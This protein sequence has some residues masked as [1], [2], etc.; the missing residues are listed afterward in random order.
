MP[1]ALPDVDK[2]GVV[3]DLMARMVEALAMGEINAAARHAHVME[4]IGAGRR[5]YFGLGTAMG[6]ALGV[7]VGVLR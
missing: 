3:A 6:F 4:S 2:L 7:L 5:L 1:S